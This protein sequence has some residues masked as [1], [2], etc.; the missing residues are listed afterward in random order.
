MERIQKALEKA[1]EQRA[2]Q[3]G[4]MVA[5]STTPIV[6]QQVNKIPDEIHYSQTQSVPLSE[7]VLKANRI[8]AGI[9]GHPN[10]DVFRI[11][12][13]KL[14]HR[15]RK[16]GCNTLAI[17]SP[18]KGGGKSVISANLA[19]AMAMEM[20]QTV[21][22]V[23]LD[24]RKPSIHKYFGFEPEKGLADYLLDGVELPDLLVNPGIERL[25]ILPAGRSVSQSSELLSTP[26]MINLVEDITSRYSS[27][28]ILFDLPPLL[29]MDDALT[30]L[31]NVH[32]SILVMEEG[33]NTKEEIQQSMRLLENSNLLGTVY[34]KARA[35]KHSP[36]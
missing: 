8:V 33:G 20:N 14:L 32:A 9:Q 12:R 24:L 4:T 13:T 16:E 27:R 5:E 31:P 22:L 21:M 17:T 2:K 18:L 10:A 19:I 28:F 35:V 29:G 3:Q 30:F 6:S 34:N 25:V 15:M 26:R 23:D 7:G 1:K 11:L 36:Y